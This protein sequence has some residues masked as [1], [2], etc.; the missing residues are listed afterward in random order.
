MLFV[1]LS[2]DK[3]IIIWWWKKIILEKRN[4]ERTLPN[5]L[6]DI[7]GK[8]FYSKIFIVNW[9]GS[10]TSIRVWTLCINMLNFLYKNQIEIFNISKIDLYSLFVKQ[11]LLPSK[12][13]LYIWQTKNYWN[14][15]FQSQSYD[16]V[17]A[18]DIWLKNKWDLFLDQT[19]EDIDDRINID[20]DWQTLLL[21]FRN[22]TNKVD[23]KN[24]WISPSNHVQP[25]YIIQPNITTKQ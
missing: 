17:S 25:I 6:K 4:L 10:F 18:S 19:F 1:N 8:N 22:K 24:M 13:L 21:N 23:I 7:F 5:T 16:Q 2:L 12:W 20:F 9:P 15:D 3:I 14:F 11:N